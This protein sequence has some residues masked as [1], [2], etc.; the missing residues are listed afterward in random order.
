MSPF[1]SRIKK[2]QSAFAGHFISGLLI[3]AP[4]LIVAVVFHW[5]FG[6]LVS[7]IENVPLHFI[8][9]SAN[10]RMAG[11]VRFLI[12]IGILLSGIFLV[13]SLG[14]ISRQYL[15]S[16]FLNSV[17]ETI[18]KIPFFGSV[19]SSLNQLLKAVSNKGE[20]QFHRVVYVEYPRKEIWSVAFVT[21][22][23]NLKGLPPGYISVFI[24]AVPLP[25]SG[26]HLMVKEAD[27][28]ESGLGVDEAFT[29]MLSLGTAVPRG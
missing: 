5:I 18:A 23:A 12:V 19:Y 28:I 3:L 10:S 13:S 25:T 14:F 8:F 27:V 29:L 21:G 6:G 22:K 16:K 26:F 2:F 15:G 24:P 17:K 1:R 7:W 11:F 4:L 9:D 20:K